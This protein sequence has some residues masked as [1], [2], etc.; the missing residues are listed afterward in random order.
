MTILASIA[1]V[2]GGIIVGALAVVFALAY[3]LRGIRFR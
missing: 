2:V 1:M 3:A